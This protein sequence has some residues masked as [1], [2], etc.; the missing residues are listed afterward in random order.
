M[1]GAANFGGFESGE[2]VVIFFGGCVAL[3]G[4]GCL[5][6]LRS[7]WWIGEGCGCASN[8]WGRAQ[9]TPC[10]VESLEGCSMGCEGGIVVRLEYSLARLYIISQ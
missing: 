7:W 10:G 6:D 2:C 9:D 3:M 1:R 5:S 8:W 4:K